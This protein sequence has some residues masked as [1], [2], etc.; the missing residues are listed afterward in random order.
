MDFESHFTVIRDIVTELMMAG[1]TPEEIMSNAFWPIVKDQTGDIHLR[2]FLWEMRASIP[3]G[4]STEQV[5]T[6]IELAFHPLRT[7]KELQV[8][9]SNAYLMRSGLM[10]IDPVS[11]VELIQHYRAAYVYNDRRTIS[12][13]HNVIFKYL[14]VSDVAPTY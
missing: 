4:R 13:F 7:F 10:R 6:M 1:A 5:D 11:S 8:S 2:A 14:G 12:M 9:L 3:E